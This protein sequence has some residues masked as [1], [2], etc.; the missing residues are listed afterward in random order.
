MREK[1][2]F[3]NHSIVVPPDSEKDLLNPTY[4]CILSFILLHLY[5]TRCH[6]QQDYPNASLTDVAHIVAEKFRHFKV[7]QN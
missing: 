6:V 4:V 5:R 2:P 7:K 3:V 1:D